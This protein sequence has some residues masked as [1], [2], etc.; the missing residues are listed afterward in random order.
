M[1]AA[2]LGHRL[3]IRQSTVAKLEQS[4]RDGTIT[5]NSLER[6]AGA[7][8]CRLVYAIVPETTYSQI[9]DSQAK[10]RA[11]EVIGIVQSSMA[12]EGQSNTAAVLESEVEVLSGE[13][14]RTLS[15]E[16]WNTNE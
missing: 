14:V 8:S 12:L 9:L 11:E 7:M 3:G 10:L 4:E 5:L 1:S 2:Q 15:R 6:L 13:L 16:I